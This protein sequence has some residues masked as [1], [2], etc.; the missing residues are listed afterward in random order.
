L[1]LVVDNNFPT[2]PNVG[3]GQFVLDAGGLVTAGMNTEVRIYTARRSQNT[4]DEM[5]NGAMFTPGAFGVDTATEQWKV[6]Y[7]GGTYG[8]DAFNL[9]YKEPQI[10]PPAPPIPTPSGLPAA[11]QRVFFN[12][13]AA[14]FVELP[15]IL[16]VLNLANWYHFRVCDR[17]HCDPTFSPYGSFIFEDGVYWIGT[18]FAPKTAI[19]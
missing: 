8:G 16:P 11:E 5:I 18:E 6:Y 13:E 4:I 7:P 3:P 17:F 14:N 9:Y 10:I 1:T 15:Y 2:A 12:L 19:Q